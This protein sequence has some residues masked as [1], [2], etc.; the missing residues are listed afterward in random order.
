MI[1]MIASDMD[2]T[3]LDPNQEISRTNQEMIRKAQAAG[4]I[5]VIAT[6][7]SFTEAIP[8]IEKTGLKF[9]MITSNGAQIFDANHKMLALE[10]IPKDQGIQIAQILKKSGVYFEIATDR[11]VY[12]TNQA[13]RV[14]HSAQSILKNN[15]DI[16]PQKAIAMSSNYLA[17]L[18]VE[19]VPTYEIL[20]TNSSIHLLK[21]MAFSLNERNPLS[22][23]KDRLLELP[24][25]K[26][27]SS[28]AGNI[29]INQIKAQKGKALARFAAMNDLSAKEIMAI[30]DSE[31]D[32]NML[33]TAG[34]SVAM[35]NALE[36]VKEKV[37]WI[38]GINSEDGVAMA[39]R[40][41]LQI[42]NHR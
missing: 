41:L 30:G 38:T 7:R 4:L 42:E 28:A 36:D 5:F 25:L 39:I 32:L 34:L 26:V 27:T 10:E 33:E 31:N 40:R 37:D 17:R 11:G 13:E 29:E 8:P 16:S 23:L 20:F 1:K 21:F 12:S 2:G 9:P 35:E 15:P 19:Y 14:T 22:A 3:L 18:A 24:N 6:G